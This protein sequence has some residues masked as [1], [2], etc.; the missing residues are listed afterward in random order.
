M[1]L[2]SVCRVSLPAA[3][4]WSLVSCAG[5]GGLKKDPGFVAAGKAGSGALPEGLDFEVSSLDAAQCAAWLDEKLWPYIWHGEERDFAL[6]LSRVVMKDGVCRQYRIFDSPSVRT[7]H[8]REVPAAAVTGAAFG[9]VVDNLK[10]PRTDRNHA[11]EI[12]APWTRAWETWDVKAQK[13]TS[14]G[15]V[16]AESVT[17]YFTT[18]A[19][20]VKAREVMMRL[21]VLAGKGNA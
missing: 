13:V 7:Y 12:R 15:R 4:V 20:A 14:R 5:V 8:L 3:I 19:A 10:G 6:T 21:A 2:F 11:F 9:P 16:E 1:N 17:F 18:R